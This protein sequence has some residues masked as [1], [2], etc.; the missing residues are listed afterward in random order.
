MGLK[1]PVAL[2]N[3]VRIGSRA[4]V[5]TASLGRTVSLPLRKVNA[6][7]PWLGS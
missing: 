1:Y 3:D 5:Q 6:P 4:A 2:G 7:R